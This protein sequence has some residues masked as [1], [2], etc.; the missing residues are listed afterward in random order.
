MSQT[1]SLAPFPWTSLPPELH[2][3]I[4]TSLSSQKPRGWSTCAAVCSSWRAILEPQNF[5]T[6]SLRATCLP[7]LS[8]LISVRTRP[9][10]RHITLTIELPR[11]G[12]PTCQR[13]AT[14]P[15]RNATI[16]RKAVLKLFKVLSTWAPTGRSL[17]LELNAS[18]PSDSEH[19]FKNYCFGRGHEDPGDWS[20][21]EKAIRWHD[22]KH[23]W[24]DGQQVRAPGAD[25]IRRLFAPL[26]LN[27]P[28]DIPVVNVVTGFCIRRQLRRQLLPEVLQAILEKLPRL[29]SVVYEFWRL[30]RVHCQIA[31][32]FGT[33]N[34][35]SNTYSIPFSPHLIS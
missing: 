13:N 20:L 34:P 1:H 30:R 27:V 31:C 26:C 19:Y 3:L 29:E 21:E 23:G 22:P 18:S 32:A 24:V 14:L 28:R 16:F 9:L 4:L 5:H 8:S 33:F 12:C 17:V 15:T 35:V 25:A 11:Y 10:I 6:L 2:L 7:D